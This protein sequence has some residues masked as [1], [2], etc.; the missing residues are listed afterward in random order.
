MDKK[1]RQALIGLPILTLGCWKLLYQADRQR[2][3]PLEPRLV[4][5]LQSSPVRSLLKD[6]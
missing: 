4:K 1:A 2:K 6:V 3:H 5:Q